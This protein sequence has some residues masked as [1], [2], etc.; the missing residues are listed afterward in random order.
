M[1]IKLIKYK[2]DWNESEFQ[3]IIYTVYRIMISEN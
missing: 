2:N 3:E 1:I